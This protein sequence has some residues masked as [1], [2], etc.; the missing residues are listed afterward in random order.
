MNLKQEISHLSHKEEKNKENWI[1]IANLKS[2]ILD[3]LSLFHVSF[4]NPLWKNF[5]HDT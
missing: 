5:D 2:F 4:Q 1:E 3:I